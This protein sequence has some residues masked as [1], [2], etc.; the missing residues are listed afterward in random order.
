MTGALDGIKAVLIVLGILTMILVFDYP[1]VRYT[2]L[3]AILGLI[4]SVYLEYGVKI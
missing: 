4:F 1:K 2:L 3:L